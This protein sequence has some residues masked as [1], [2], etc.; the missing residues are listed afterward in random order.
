MKKLKTLLKLS[1]EAKKA[2]PSPP[3]GPI[4]GQYGVNLGL[5]CSTYNDLT[6]NLEGIVP[7]EISIFNDKSFTLNLKTAPTSI[8]LLKQLKKTKGSSKPNLQKI[9]QLKISEL[10]PIAETKLKELNTKNLTQAVLS[11][12]GTAQSLGISIV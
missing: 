10:F 1:L 8:L 4:L 7:V 12:Q 11:I 9:G 2:N 3:V 6:K 5:F